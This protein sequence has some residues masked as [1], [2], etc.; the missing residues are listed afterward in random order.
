MSKL[1]DTN[2]R[3]C[4]IVVLKGMFVTNGGVWKAFDFSLAT[5]FSGG[6]CEIVGMLMTL[7]TIGGAVQPGITISYSVCA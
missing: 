4:G 3:C 1:F 5:L 2:G 7:S 6:V